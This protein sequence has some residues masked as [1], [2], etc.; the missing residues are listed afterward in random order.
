MS[1]HLAHRGGPTPCHTHLTNCPELLV[2]AATGH[3]TG[4]S[5]LHNVSLIYV[6]SIKQDEHQGIKLRNS[7]TAFQMHTHT[8][9]PKELDLFCMKTESQV[10]TP[11]AES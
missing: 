10:F 2:P 11:Q 6:P 3:L 5:R 7:K 8:C 4:N 1:C 9:F